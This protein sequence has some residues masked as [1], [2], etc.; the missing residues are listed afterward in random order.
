MRTATGPSVMSPRTHGDVLAYTDSN[1]DGSDDG[2]SD[3]VAGGK[4]RDQ[5]NRPHL[6]GTYAQQVPPTGTV[7]LFKMWWN[8][9]IWIR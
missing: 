7:L 6:S 1:D 8:Y 4:A 9:M 5:L 3:D 2:D